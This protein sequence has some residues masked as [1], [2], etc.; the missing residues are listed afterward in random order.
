VAL[1]MIELLTKCLKQPEAN[2]ELFEFC[3]DAFI[4]LDESKDA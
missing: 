4:H 2:P 3:E 1:F